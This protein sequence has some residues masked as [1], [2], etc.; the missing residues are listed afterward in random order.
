MTSIFIIT[1][2]TRTNEVI[3]NIH[4]QYNVETTITDF[5]TKKK[6]IEEFNVITDF[7]LF[8]LRQ[9]NSFVSYTGH[10]LNMYINIIKKNKVCFDC[11]EPILR[12]HF[13]EHVCECDLESDTDSDYSDETDDSDGCDCRT[14]TSLWSEFINFLFPLLIKNGYL[15]FITPCSWMTGSTNKQSGNI[16][17]GIFKKNT[18]LYLDIERCGRYFN[19][20]STFSYYL[21]QKTYKNTP[22]DMGAS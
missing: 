1:P 4:Q 8:N 21:I 20:G 19:V 11:V 7:F 3:L 12:N 18:L 6:L 2:T 5:I 17:N 13:E 16:L 15:L 22:F 14:G 10:V 9:P